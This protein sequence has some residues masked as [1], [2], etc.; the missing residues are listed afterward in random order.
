MS[1]PRFAVVGHP[2]KGKSSI[3][4]TLAHDDAVKIEQRSGSTKKSQVFPMLVDDKILY[5]LIDTPGFQR[6]HACHDYLSKHCDDASQRA[7]AIEDFFQEHKSGDRFANECELLKPILNGAGIIYV[8]DGSKPY[9]PEYEAEMEILRWTGQPSLALINPIEGDEYI[10]EWE[11]ALGQYFKTVR[12]FDAHN[13]EFKKQIGLLKIFGELSESWQAPLHSAVKL[14]RTQRLNYHQNAADTLASAIVDILNHTERQ[15][16]ALG[17]ATSPIESLLKKRYE[18][19]V[20]KIERNSRDKIENIYAYFKLERSESELKLGSSDLLDQESWYLFGLNK[21]QLLTLAAGAGASAGA[22]IDIG[23]GGSSLLLGSAIG[24]IGGGLSAWKF[25]K[26]IASITFKG[27][28]T[29]G[30]TL[31][32]GPAKHPNLPFVLLGRALIHHRFICQ[33][34]HANR[35]QV[36]LDSKDEPTNPL[37]SLSVS[38]KTKLMKIFQSIRKQRNLFANR[39]ELA[40]I[41]LDELKNVDLVQEP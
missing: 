41:I 32:Y 17:L 23:L 11:N 14:L 13:A 24:G 26:R 35:D 2:N 30:H 29:G 6:A 39:D 9:G 21:K 18:E 27:L 40:A 34:T 28:P 19:A 16:V 1:L 10:E 5:E 4:A 12:V 7:A 37:H 33:R 20:R 25:S 3:V 8:V 22:I 38:D 31:Q 36:V 15:N